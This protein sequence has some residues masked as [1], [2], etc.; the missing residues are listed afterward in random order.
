MARPFGGVPP[1]FAGGHFTFTFNH[2]WVLCGSHDLC[3]TR[4]MTN[5]MSNDYPQFSDPETCSWCTTVCEDSDLN[6]LED[7]SRI[8]D[9]CE[10]E[11]LLSPIGW[12]N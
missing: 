4:H 7:G 6:E 3:Y 1:C 12:D 8:C 5:P 10:M 2:Y 11:M 9:E